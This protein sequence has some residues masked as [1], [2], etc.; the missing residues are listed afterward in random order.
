MNIIELSVFDCD[1]RVE[2]M[3]GQAESLLVP[4]LR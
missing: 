1:I 4:P 2:C 3:D